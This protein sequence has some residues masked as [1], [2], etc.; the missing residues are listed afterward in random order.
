[1]YVLS[2][3]GS[4][5]CFCWLY[6]VSAFSAAKNI[7]NLIL[8]LLISWCPCVVISW[9]D[10]KRSFLW[11]ACYFDKTLLNFALLHFVLQGQ[12]CLLFW[13]TLDFLLFNSN[14]LW[15]KGS[16]SVLVV[17]GLVGFYKTD[18]PQL[19]WHK[20]LHIFGLLWYWMV[21]P[22]NKLRS[23]CHFWDCSQVLHFGLFCWLW[24]L[25]HFI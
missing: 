13:V 21:C 1:M 18:Q 4:R 24:G 25:L 15:W 9:V 14:P 6:G 17:E 3:W 11:P 19:L 2:R 8:V 7:I 22:G 12:T 23:L 10:G 5:S 16:F 20:W